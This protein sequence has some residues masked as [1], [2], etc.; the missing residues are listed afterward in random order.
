MK[1]DLPLP[2]I[3]RT[4]NAKQRW[5]IGIAIAL[6]C[7]LV[8]ASVYSRLNKK[9]IQTSVKSPVMELA[10]A[11]VARVA[12]RELQIVLPVSGTLTALHQAVVKAK[13]AGE[14]RETPVAEGVS[15]R[16]GAVVVRLD[17]A[18]LKARLGVQQA[19]VDDARARLALAAKNN[20]NNN[21]LL[22]QKFISQ[23]AVDAAQNSVEL[24]TAAVK[25]ASAQRDIALR[26]LEDANVRAPI[27]GI[28]SKRYVQ[29]GEKASPDMPLFAVVDLSQ[30]IL[31]AQVPA[32]EIPRVAIGE[33]VNFSVDGFAQRKF[34]GKVVRINPAAEPGSR[35]ITVYV[36]VANE[37]AAL[38]SG[39][40]AKG[41]ITLDKSTPMPVL[42]IAALYESA[43][44]TSVYKIES[45]K[46]VEQIVKVGLR[47]EADGLIEIVGGLEAGT[48][49]LAV[50]LDGVK[51]G[52]EVRL[53]VAVGE[54]VKSGPAS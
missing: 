49:V 32:S 7:L 25:S 51:P 30:L 52:T 21:A 27:D 28:I 37:D 54:P 22:R 5:V 17:T 34:S 38:K 41:G 4:R 40:F 10:N 46:V 42:P 8:A 23:N 50:K 44:V 2:A 12:V 26:A 31:E 16:R 1:N 48:P 53:P 33:I 36:A 19:A 14:V 13:V 24:A 39:M 45:G 47:N 3:A 43:G 6:L 15:V 20:D 35:S 9:K 11:D 29:P 18:D